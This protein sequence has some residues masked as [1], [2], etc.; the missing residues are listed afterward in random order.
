MRQFD[1]H[2]IARPRRDTS[3]ARISDALEK[4]AA[5]PFRRPGMSLKIR[6]LVIA[7]A[8]GTARVP[9][10]EDRKYPMWAAHSAVSGDHSQS[11]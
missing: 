1:R 5:C 6:R 2:E 7:P 11:R 10:G 3:D 4:Q 8:H 9:G